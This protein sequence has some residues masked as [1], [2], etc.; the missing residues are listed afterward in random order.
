MLHWAGCCRTRSWIFASRRKL[1]PAIQDIDR[2]T[3]A[4][5]LRSILHQLDDRLRLRA[6]VVGT[7]QR[8]GVRAWPPFPLLFSARRSSVHS[9][10]CVCVLGE[11]GRSWIP[12][13]T[14]SR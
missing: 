12:S 6:V 5:L 9:D 1:I 2:Q 7:A 11:S 14:A 8:A 10:S 3:D 4:V 13:I